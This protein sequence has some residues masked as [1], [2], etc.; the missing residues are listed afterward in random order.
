[1][2]KNRLPDNTKLDPCQSADSECI[3]LGPC[4]STDSEFIIL[5]PGRTRTQNSS[6]SQNFGVMKKSFPQADFPKNIHW[7]QGTQYP[8]GND[9]T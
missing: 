8:K 5:D 2:K 6:G 9:L 3:I 4:R 7:T 1:M